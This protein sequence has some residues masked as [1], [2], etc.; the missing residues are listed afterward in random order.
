MSYRLE[1]VSFAYPDRPIFEGL[2]L[3]LRAGRFHGV[4]GPNGCGK[5]TLL[6]LLG[7]LKKPTRGRIFWSGEDL[8]AW[9][10]KALARRI[11]VVPQEFHIDFPFT[12]GEV[13]TMGRYPH[14]AR[15]EAPAASDRET[16]AAVMARTDTAAFTE[17]RITELSGGERQ[18]VIF[19]RALAQETEVLLLDEATSALDINHSLR[20]LTI[21]ARGVAEKGLTVVAVFQDVNLAAQFCDQLIFFKG[22]A[23]VAQGETAAV[24]TPS[25][26]A[27]T[28]GVIAQV[29]IDP[30]VGVNQVAYRPVDEVA[31]HE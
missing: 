11:A 5:S 23:V 31:S 14:L 12:A 19:A 15:F 28:F 1:K 30:F 8:A 27:A 2:D 16:V 4:I 13:V 17:R 10:P 18:R 24:L 7:G 21:A 25:T 20:L 22:G 3:E 6:D 9:A 26:L 29:R